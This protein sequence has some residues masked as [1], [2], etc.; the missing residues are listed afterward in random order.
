MCSIPPPTLSNGH[1]R[2]PRPRP[3]GLQRRRPHRFPP[4]LLSNFPISV[5]VA[6]TGIL[7]HISLGFLQGLVL[8]ASWIMCFATGTTM[9]TTGLGT[10]F[11]ILSASGFAGTRLGLCLVAR[12][13]GS[14]VGY[15][16][17]CRELGGDGGVD[18]EVIARPAGA[19]LGLLLVVGGW[20]TR[21]GR[22]CRGGSQRGSAPALC[23]HSWCIQPY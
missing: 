14:W 15:D 23:L 4:A 3:A 12:W 9:S 16:P 10:T 22:A 18:G 17:G 8:S 11:T 2:R 7:A 5:D 1:N 6:V 13:R 21:M 20:G 19:S